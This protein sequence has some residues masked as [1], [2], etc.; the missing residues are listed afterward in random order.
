MLRW[1]FSVIQLS[2]WHSY[3]CSNPNKFIGSPSCFWTYYFFGLGWGWL[4]MDFLGKV[5]QEARSFTMSGQIESGLLD[6]SEHQTLTN[7]LIDYPPTWG[8][9]SCLALP[10]NDGWLHT[11]VRHFSL[12]SW[13]SL[14]HAVKPTPPTFPGW[15]ILNSAR[16]G[17]Y[18]A[19]HED[20]SDFL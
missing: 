3:S 9:K 7:N 15:N 6:L 10:H 4:E 19:S 20:F 2:K 12:S 13:V 16:C 11:T 17:I 5:P 14:L 1:D 8:S 18:L